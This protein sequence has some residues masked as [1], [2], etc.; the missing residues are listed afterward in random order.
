MGSTLSA[1]DVLR[2]D[3]AARRAVLVGAGAALGY[4]ALVWPTRVEPDTPSDHAD[5]VT[6]GNW[7]WPDGL[8]KPVATEDKPR[9][10]WQRVKGI[11]SIPLYAFRQWAGLFSK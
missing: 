2:T 8:P 6:T 10:L 9:T 1:L 4:L 11:L 5:R 3:K 7:R